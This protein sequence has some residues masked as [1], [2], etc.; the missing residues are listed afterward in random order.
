METRT[1]WDRRAE[2]SDGQPLGFSASSVWDLSTRFRLQIRMILRCVNSVLAPH[3][4]QRRAS[5]LAERLS[6]LPAHECSMLTAP[7]SLRLPVI[8]HDRW[9]R[10]FG[11]VAAW[12]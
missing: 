3:R 2:L 8:C 7:Y 9:E 1:F 10:W 5:P 11:A 6:P 4:G 12:M